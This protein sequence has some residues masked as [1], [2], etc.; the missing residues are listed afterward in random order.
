MRYA[1]TANAHVQLHDGRGET[2][3]DVVAGE[4]DAAHVDA[5]VIDL[6]IR[7]GLASVVDETPKAPKSKKETP[8]VT[9]Q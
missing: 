8:D 1:I 9:V 2:S 3:V 5:A 7:S 4:V 6:L